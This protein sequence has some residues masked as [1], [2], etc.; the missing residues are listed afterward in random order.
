VVG[1]AQ[2]REH[3]AVDLRVVLGQVQAA[4]GGQAFEQDVAELLAV[5]MAAGA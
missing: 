1:L 5:C 2:A 4:I 3:G